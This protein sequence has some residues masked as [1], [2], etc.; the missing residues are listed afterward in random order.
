MS[1]MCSLALRPSITVLDGSTAPYDTTPLACILMTLP[2]SAALTLSKSSVPSQTF[3]VGSTATPPGRRMAVEAAA[4]APARFVLMK[5]RG[6]D[7]ALVR[8]RLRRRSQVGVP[9]LGSSVRGPDNNTSAFGRREFALR[10][11]L[12]KILHPTEAAPR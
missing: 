8:V 10:T 1:V 2:L 5:K 12:Q 11:L 4:I 9:N 3:G 7:D 6:D